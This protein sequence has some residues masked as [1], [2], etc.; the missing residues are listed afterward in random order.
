[1]EDDELDPLVARADIDGLV[2]LVD[3]RCE[4]RDWPGLLRTR[5]RSRAALGT[6]RQLWPVATL[7]EYRLALLAPAEW[8]ARVLHEDGG[9]FAVGPL[10]EVIAQNHRWSEL[11]DL[12]PAG[13]RRSFVAQ[14]R[15]L[16]GEEI[17]PADL[18]VD[19]LETPLRLLDWEPEYSLPIYGDDGVRCDGPVDR[20]P[21]AWTLVE[22]A[23]DC[24]LLD[25]PVLTAAARSLVATWLDA[26]EG[27]MRVAVVEGGV[28][29]ALRALDLG[30]ARVSRLDPADALDW[31]AWCA[32]SGGT[33]GRRRGAA[34]G[35]FD[36][37]WFVTAVGGLDWDELGP[38]PGDAVR[39]V[40]MSTDWWRL[41]VGAEAPFHLAIAA[42]R[43]VD[44]D[45]HD[46]AHPGTHHDDRET[47]VVV[48]T[49]Q[50]P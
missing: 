42:E 46:G 13:P 21:A 39:D 23:P 34:A 41:D 25:D 12:L 49:D 16:R 32:A 1:M 33:H 44:D 40:L 48:A 38:E 10:T 35:R 4:S 17:D 15:V 7:A 45:R 24:E 31:L 30:S 19:V 43:S 29:Q 37:W 28:A 20:R 8:A 14:E 50:R 11:R 27:A 22:A 36:A 9:R 6:G 47:I 2:R 26:S 18:D 5:D 3:A